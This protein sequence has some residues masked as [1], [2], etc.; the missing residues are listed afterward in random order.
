M[1]C[2]DSADMS[3]GTTANRYRGGQPYSLGALPMPSPTRGRRRPMHTQCSCWRA[4]T[5]ECCALGGQNGNRM[6]TPVT[7]SRAQTQTG[8]GFLQHV[9]SAVD[10]A[11]RRFYDIAVQRLVH[12]I[13][14]RKRFRD[15]LQFGGG[16]LSRASSHSCTVPPAI[17]DDAPRRHADKS[18]ATTHSE[19]RKSRNTAAASE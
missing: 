14:S 15:P 3:I 8:F 13:S 18:T 19:T 11:Q 2:S 7:L 10:L 17:Y 9:A 6:V 16:R 12:G 1:E 4:I 5:R